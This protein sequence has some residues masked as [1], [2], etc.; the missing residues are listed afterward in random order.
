MFRIVFPQ[1]DQPLLTGLLG[2]C[3][4]L[5]A[6]HLP[7]ATPPRTSGAAGGLH[8]LLHSTWFGQHWSR[9]GL[10]HRIR[11]VVLD[12][13]DALLSGGFADA[14]NRILEV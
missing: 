1:V 12:E 13:A 3:Q 14:T 2:D 5:Q 8:G 11:H 9:E 6:A 4:R 7:S 10:P